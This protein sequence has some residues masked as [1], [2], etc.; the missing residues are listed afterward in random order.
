MNR[1]PVAGAASQEP[2]PAAAGAWTSRDPGRTPD[3][4]AVDEVRRAG[5]RILVQPDGLAAAGGTIQIEGDGGGI[6]CQE[7]PSYIG[8]G[9]RGSNG[10]DAASEVL[11]D[12]LSEG[13]TRDREREARGDPRPDGACHGVQRGSARRRR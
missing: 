12:W 6:R 9:L 8:G 10:D 2:P 7:P 3:A 13:R 11:H 1:L 5:D 4:A